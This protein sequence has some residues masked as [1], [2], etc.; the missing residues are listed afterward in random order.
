M[1]N[2]V[3]SALREVLE[4]VLLALVIFVLMRAVVQNFKVEG[5]SMEPNLHNEQYLLVNKVEYFA[6]EMEHVTTIL[7]I[8]QWEGPPLIYV[9]HPPQR[10][11]V[12][13]FRFPKE[14]S[15]DFIKRVIATPG[16]RVEIESGKV[17]IDGM[18]LNEDFIAEGPHYTLK[19]QTVPTDHYFVLGDNRNNSSD[20]HVWGMVPRENIVGKA[21]LSYWPI[22]RWGLA[23]NYTV[24][25]TTAT[26]EAVTQ[27]DDQ[28]NPLRSPASLQTGK[29]LH[30][31]AA[32]FRGPS[33]LTTSYTSPTNT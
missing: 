11:D 13:V 18:L 7:P 9:F 22:N 4:T 25:V 8:V 30:E 20:S 32:T 27:N 21:W 6:I 33:P 14:P 29:I 31:I 15:R 23:P 3:K 5:S 16:E 26:S 24:S 1:G 17:Y 19:E 12:V 10:G 2:D 28:Q